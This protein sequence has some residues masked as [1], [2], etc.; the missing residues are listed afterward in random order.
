MTC[1]LPDL[2]RGLLMTHEAPDQ[3]RGRVVAKVNTTLTKKLKSLQTQDYS[4]LST[5]D[6]P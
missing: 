6:T 1:S 2:I 4:V 5:V 3:L